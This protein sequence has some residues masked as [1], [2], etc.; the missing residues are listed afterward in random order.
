MTAAACAST[1]CGPP[2]PSSSPTPPPSRPS[3]G[4]RTPTLTLRLALALTLALPL[5][6]PLP[7]SLSQTL[8]L[9]LTLTEQAKGV[10]HVSLLR[11]LALPS[12]QYGP[13]AA[14]AR[15]AH[16]VCERWSAQLRGARVSM[17]GLVYVRE[18]QIITLR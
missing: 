3:G 13:S 17:R 2:Q 6:L 16:A 14:A 1:P 10:L 15:V 12:G 7:L 4:T 5:A 11:I 18:E 8:T 9:T